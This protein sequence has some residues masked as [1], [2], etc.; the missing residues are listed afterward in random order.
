MRLRTAALVAGLAVVGAG[1]FVIMPHTPTGVV[2][3]VSR[4]KLECGDVLLTQT[5]TGTTDPYEVWFYFRPSA[6]E[7][8]HQYFVDFEAPFWWGGLTRASDGKSSQLHSYL[9]SEGVFRCENAA[10]ELRGGRRI[11]ARQTLTD[12]FNPPELQPCAVSAR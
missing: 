8:W 3:E 12:P 1:W 10:F 4:A 2:Q 5:F 7:P 6:N 9:Q 11:P